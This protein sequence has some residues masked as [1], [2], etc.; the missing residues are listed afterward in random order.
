VP[1][2]A[3]TLLEAYPADEHPIDLATIERIARGQIASEDAL[4]RS[5]HRILFCDTDILATTIW[6]DV[7]VG[8]CPTWLAREASRRRYDLTLLTDIDIPWVADPVR[9]R[10]DDRASFFERCECALRGAGRAYVRISGSREAR[11]HA[12]QQAVDTLLI[13]GQ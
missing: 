11:L 1:E 13:D 5:A 9:F 3:R 10:P 7:L 2:Y 12:A 6:S 8:S 4:A